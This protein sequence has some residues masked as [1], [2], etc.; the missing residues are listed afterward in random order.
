[1]NDEEKRNELAVNA[2]LQFIESEPAFIPIPENSKV[3]VEYLQ[4]HSELL[5]TEIA[6]YQQAFRACQDRLRFEHQMSAEEFKT[7]VV[8]PAWQKKQHD[9]PQPSQIDL[10][11][12]E[13]FESHGFRDSLSN[14]A[15]VDRY[16]KDHNIEDYSL[17]NLA[18]AVETLGDC[19]VLEL[20][21]AA[22]E[23]MPSHI[24]KKV[25]EQEFKERE[26]N[27]PP[28][29]SEKPWGVNWTDWINSR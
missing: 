8:I 19:L 28:A 5:P 12:K 3:I 16:M 27:R 2:A 20:S 13:L 29:T 17:E 4:N 9:K 14:R 18:H 24:Y 25:I 22:I 26:A 1:M 10:T 6:S 23:Q 7:A 21:D 11:L 15:K